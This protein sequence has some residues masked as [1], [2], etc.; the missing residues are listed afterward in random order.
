M[1][2]GAEIQERAKETTIYWTLSRWC[3]CCC[4]QAPVFAP[5][6]A[7]V[8]QSNNDY[9]QLKRLGLTD[10]DIQSFYQV[11]SQLDDDESGTIDQYEFTDAIGTTVDVMEGHA[12]LND[13]LFGRFDLDHG[14]E[15]DGLDFR[16]FVVTLWNYATY[17]ETELARFAFFNLCEVDRS[18]TLSYDQVKSFLTTFARTTADDGDD[19]D[20]DDKPSSALKMQQDLLDM[21]TNGD[22]M[23]DLDEWMKFT[24]NH[25]RIMLP[26]IK[27]QSNVRHR[28]MGINF[29]KRQMATKEN[30]MRHL[31]QVNMHDKDITRA[32][33]AN[34]NVVVG[35][36]DDHA[37]HSARSFRADE[38]LVPFQTAPRPKE[39]SSAAYHNTLTS[40]ETERKVQKKKVKEKEGSNPYAYRPKKKQSG[41]ATSLTKRRKH[42]QEETSAAMMRVEA[43]RRKQ[44]ANKQKRE[45]L[46]GM[47]GGKREEKNVVK[48][49]GGEYHRATIN[50]KILRRFS[51]KRC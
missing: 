17:S 26:L 31:L 1:M 41:A 34:C 27:A 3:R 29:W 32:L 37:V 4:C 2:T 9:T 51:F 6:D 48:R 50:R 10:L 8:G 14:T 25:K 12:G 39:A 40:K 35:D 49:E 13:A 43:I 22:R 45:N 15:S 44:A 20:D 5:N 38:T 7:T 11:F 21:D 23:I 24:H 46:G 36:E 18:G 19:D 30:T 16:E 47:F 33:H 42:G 28:I